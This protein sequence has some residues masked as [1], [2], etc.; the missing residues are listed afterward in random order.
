MHT[1]A[2][3]DWKWLSHNGHTI[4]NDLQCTYF[5]DFFLRVLLISVPARMR[6]QFEYLV[7]GCSSCMFTACITVLLCPLWLYLNELGCI[8]NSYFA[9][10]LLL[11]ERF[12]LNF[13]RWAVAFVWLG[14]WFVLTQCFYDHLWYLGCHCDCVIFLAR[15]LHSK[16]WKRIHVMN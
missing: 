9:F 13:L 8:C 6:V 14:T 11:I 2:T 4:M 16:M 10:S 1:D 7:L 12:E 3:I 5:L 15:T